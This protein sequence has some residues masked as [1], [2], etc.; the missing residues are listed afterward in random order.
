MD[1]M[2]DHLVGMEIKKIREEL[3]LTQDQLAAQ[4][5]VAG[6]ETITRSALAKIESGQRHIYMLEAKI[7]AKVLHISL[8]EL[9][10]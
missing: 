4:V 3:G 6:C 9:F 1:Y 7:F 8:D 5:Q 10:A 2:Y